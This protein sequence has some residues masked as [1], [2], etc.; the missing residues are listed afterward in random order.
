[1]IGHYDGHLGDWKIYD[2]AINIWITHSLFLFLYIFIIIIIMVRGKISGR[3]LM[4]FLSE[5]PEAAK[6][7]L[8]E[9]ANV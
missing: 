9:V 2:P 4:A 1:M 6:E 7:V 8:E 5:P 3:I